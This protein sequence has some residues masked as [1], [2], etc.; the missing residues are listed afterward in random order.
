MKYNK[1]KKSKDKPKGRKVYEH[2]FNNHN[3]KRKK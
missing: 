2:T 3:K 1:K